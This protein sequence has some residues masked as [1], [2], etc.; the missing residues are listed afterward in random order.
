MINDLL[1]DIKNFILVND[2]SSVSKNTPFFGG[3]GI[4]ITNQ[5]PIEK[6]SFYPSPTYVITEHAEE[7][8]WLIFKLKDIFK[9]KI[10]Y[11]NKY[12]FYGRIAERANNAINNNPTI[13]MQ[14][15]LLQVIDEAKNTEVS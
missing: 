7:L 2:I 14:D 13:E 4:C 5:K 1:D 3:A 15:L 12:S 8:S 10:D 11:L 9:E 6:E